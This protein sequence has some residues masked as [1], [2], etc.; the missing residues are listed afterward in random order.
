MIAGLFIAH[1]SYTN[2]VWAGRLSPQGAAVNLFNQCL[3]SGSIKF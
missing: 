1:G 2:S 3:S